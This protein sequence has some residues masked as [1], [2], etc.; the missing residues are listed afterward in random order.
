[1][2]AL[3]VSQVADIA[4]DDLKSL[5]EY[6]PE[7]G[8]LFWRSYARTPRTSAGGISMKGYIVVKVR[9]RRYQASRLAI[10]LS[11]GHWPNGIVD[12]INGNTLDN[13][14]CNLRVVSHQQNMFN[15]KTQKNN[16][17]GIKGVRKHR[18]GRYEA[19]IRHNGKAVYIGLFD[20]KE[21]AHAAY[22]DAAEKLFGEHASHLS[23]GRP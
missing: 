8:K 9:R 5:L 13:R 22:L 19:R 18:F 6:E 12:H 3:S 10:A 2:T 15:T 4:I 14:L 23:R 1:M 21:E 17:I 11:T 7:T 16:I 20:T